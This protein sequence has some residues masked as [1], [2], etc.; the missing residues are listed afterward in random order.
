M[1]H[2]KTKLVFY[3]PVVLGIA[4][5]SL[6][7]WHKWTPTSTFH[8][9]FNTWVGYGPLYVAR[10]KGFF[11]DEGVD[12]E[13]QRIEGTGDRRA[14]L[15]AKRI[16]ALGS[17]IDDLVVG[18]SQGVPAKMVLSIDESTGADG[19]VAVNTI[20]NIKD[21]KGKT[22]AVQPGFVNHFFLLYLLDK[23]GLSSDDIK[24]QAMEP[25]AAGLAFVAGKIDVAVTWEPYLSKAKQRPDG[26]VLITSADPIVEG[27]IVDNLIVRNDVIERR[28]R[29]VQ[30]VVRAWFK[31]VEY[32]RTNPEEAN[33]IIG[34][35]FGLKP[36]EVVEML[37]GVKLFDEARNKKFLSLTGAPHTVLEVAGKAAE[38]YYRQRLISHKPDIKEIIDTSF[39]EK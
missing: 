35:E 3:I 6:F 31:A 15:I 30:R 39:I 2:E 5:I 10:E 33:A 29:D 12:V 17:T 7:L 36:S 16:E 34:K 1:K 26:H 9:A 37:S 19:I 11:K 28:R 8:I 21:L 38:L 13:L 14:A 20:K 23:A 22:V 18:A 4:A 27:V 24:I 32:L 25:D